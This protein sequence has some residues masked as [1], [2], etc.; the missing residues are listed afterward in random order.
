MN[1]SAVLYRKVNIL[2]PFFCRI[3]H[4]S[5]LALTLGLQITDWHQT[6]FNRSFNLGRSY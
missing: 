6:L 3:V 4:L 5:M 2:E 1:R